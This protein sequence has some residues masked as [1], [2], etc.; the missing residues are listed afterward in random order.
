[1]NYL[2]TMFLSLAFATMAF[3]T[4]MTA[5]ELKARFELKADIYTLDTD[6]KKIV[7]GPNTTR[8]SRTSVDSGKIHG[9][10]GSSFNGNKVFLRHS[11]EILDD[12]S[13]K[14]TI[15]EYAEEKDKTFSG[16]LERKEFILENFEPIVWKPK[17]KNPNNVVV[18]F[19]PSL[20]E[21]SKAISMNAIPLSATDAVITDSDGYLW[22]DEMSFNGK[23]SGFKTHRGALV[24]SYLPF[25]GAKELGTAEGKQIL[26]KA[27]KNFT[28]KIVSATD[29]LPSGLTAKIYGTY[30][31]A[32][33]SKRVNSVHGWDSDSE[34]R[35]L[36]GFRN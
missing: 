21:V 30:D 25:K 2:I 36:E 22:A 7:S 4:P 33:K 28:I 6:N 20:R 23:Y 15:E 9:D 1:M 12:A 14:V 24:I 29:F 17:Q 13:I 11:W 27:G 32:Q 19:I 31:P 3:A 10:W 26:L 16:L 5:Q 35:I 18:R 34:A 8:I